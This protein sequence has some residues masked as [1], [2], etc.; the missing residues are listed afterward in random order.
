LTKSQT[1]KLIAVAILVLLLALLGGYYAYYKSTHQLSFNLTASTGQTIQPPQFL[2]SFAGDT[3]KLQRPIGVLVDGDTVYACDANGRAI[4]IFNQAG[5]YKGS[6]GQT[7]TVIPLYIAKNPKDGL[8]YVSDRRMRTIH[9]F[10][11][12]GQ[13]VGDFNPNLPPDQ[14]PKFKTGGVQWEP[15]A[16]AFGPDGTMYVT[17][18][19]NGH[20]LLIFGPDGTFRRSIGTAGMVT[21]RTT[22]PTEFQFP[23]GIAVHNGLVYVTDSNNGR[24]QIFDKDGNF[25][26]IIVTQGL[27]RG[28]AFLNAFPGDK[29][30]TPNRFVVVDTLA[31]DGTIWDTK[32]TKLVDFGQQG[33]L[34]GQ[35]SYPDG[36]SIGSRNK[37]FI[38]DTSNGRIQVWG[39]PAQVSPVP[40]PTAS[41]WWL[42]CLAP[43]LLLPLLLLLRRRPFY[44]TPDFVYAMVDAEQADL[45]PGRRRKWLVSEEHYEL[46]KGIVQGEVDMSELLNAE[47]Y[48]ESDAKA[49]MD[50]LE[51]D[52]PT[53]I[54]L[55]LAQRAKVF[56]TENTDYRRLAKLLEID[57]VNRVEYIERF[58]KQADNG[59]TPGA[60]VSPQTTSPDD[61]E[62]GLPPSSGAVDTAA[63]GAPEASAEPGPEPGKDVEGTN[64]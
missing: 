18:I 36:A 31:H 46:L 63:E 55:S 42:L 32:G 2:Y 5:T 15:V 53:A 17:E 43:L 20:R 11:T 49:L 37:I 52:L 45:M 60:P 22:F 39:W 44:A 9:K 23:N 26:Q 8:L 57:V 16:I 21:D 47:P 7:S 24:V 3:V 38:A 12:A 61:F 50:R 33:V 14:L 1:R 58:V 56:T 28:I 41:P 48:S 6:F 54:V 40:V 59:S 51:I 10:T 19:L 64:E 13:Y 34:D 27:P 35:F 25:K 4:F 30:T 29:A 62:E